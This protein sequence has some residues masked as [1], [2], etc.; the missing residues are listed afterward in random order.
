M[1][2]LLLLFCSE[3]QAFYI[4]CSIC[5]L[6][7]PDYYIKAMIGSIVD[8]RIFEGLMQER[9]PHITEHLEELD[10]PL[11]LISLPW[12]LCLFIGYVPLEV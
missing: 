7:V 6:L 10:L 5:E 8:Q 2:A 3:E 12:F 4:L 9:V 1:T 11:Q